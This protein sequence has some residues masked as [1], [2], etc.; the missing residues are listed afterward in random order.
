MKKIATVLATVIALA[1]SAAMAQ[2]TVNLTGK[3]NIGA[4]K[5]GDGQTQ[6]V[7]GADGADS[8]VTLSGSENLGAGTKVNF[9]LETGFKPDTGSLDNT[10]NQLFQRQS[11]VGLSGG[12]GEVRAG[13]QYTLGFLGSIG[14]MPSTFTDP[15]LAA[16]L[17]F[18]GLASRNNDQ[19]QYWSPALAGVQVGASTQLSGDTSAKTNEVALKYTSGP[20]AVNLTTATIDNVSGNTVA[21]NAAY[22]FKVVQLAA[23]VVDKAGNGTGKGS[24]VRVTAP[25]KSLQVFTG[26]ARNSDTGVNAY[27]VGAYYALSKRTRLYAVYG[28]GNSTVTDRTAFGIDHN[29]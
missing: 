28:A 13:R 6:L 24:F 14:T 26:Y 5:T 11:W 18:N 15:Q 27:D 21:L 16:G 19:I 8:R 4:Q 2:P 20:L 17:G 1:T 22:D 9:V 3:L 23:G 25:V 12:F 7:G 29:F 10:S